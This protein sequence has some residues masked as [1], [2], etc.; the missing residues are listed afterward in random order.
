[1]DLGGRYTTAAALAEDLRRWQM[2]EP[3]TARPVSSAERLGRWARR[4]PALAS[5]TAALALRLL[6]GP[7]VVNWLLLLGEEPRGVAE[8]NQAQ[9]DADFKLARESVDKYA[10]RVSESLRLRRE[11]LRPLRKELLE[12]V[13]PFYEQLLA[14][15]SDNDEVQ[16]ERG[17]AYARL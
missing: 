8:A 6:G 10:T 16:A 1:K 4:K 13:V 12:T 15:H 5:L 7:V 2:G 17:R 9:A 11:D 3:I 14:R